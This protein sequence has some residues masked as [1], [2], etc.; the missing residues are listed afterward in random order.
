MSDRN[1]T[2]FWVD[3]VTNQV[4]VPYASATRGQDL[5]F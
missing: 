5:S 2:L 1:G 4:Y 3:P